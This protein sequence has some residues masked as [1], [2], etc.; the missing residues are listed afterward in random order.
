MAKLVEEN[1]DQD[2]KDRI[3]LVDQL[4]HNVHLQLVKKLVKKELVGKNVKR[5]NYEKI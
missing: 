4:K 3:L 1:Q 2:L 5:N